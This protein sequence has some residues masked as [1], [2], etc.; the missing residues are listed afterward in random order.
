MV[1]RYFIYLTYKGTRYHGWQQQPGEITIQQV[2]ERALSLKLNESVAVTGAGRTDAG[3]H[4]LIFAAHFDSE[5]NNLHLNQYLI[6]TLNSFLP[7][8]IA[9][10]SIVRVRNDASAR[11]SALSRSYIYRITLSK[12]PFETDTAWRIYTEP[13]IEAMNISASLLCN[14]SDFASFCRSNSGVKT[15]VCSVSDC[16]WERDG[17]KLTLHIKADRFL[18][19]MVRAV[20]GTMIDVGR[21]KISV[22]QFRKIVESRDRRAAGESAPAHGL[23]LSNIE[24]PENIF[25]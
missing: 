8:D 19:N 2:V 16:Y 13:D 10:R 14:Y 17:T 15:T 11:Y 12:E 5:I 4:A 1:N 3:V 22:D 9:I 23:Y 18:R 20:T 7:K 21:G 24:Y 6:A 25:L